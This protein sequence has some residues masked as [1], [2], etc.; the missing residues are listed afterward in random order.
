MHVVGMTVGE[1]FFDGARDTFHR[2]FVNAENYS[3]EAR[4]GERA[5]ASATTGE[6]DGGRSEGREKDIALDLFYPQRILH[7]SHHRVY[8]P[9]PFESSQ[10]HNPDNFSTHKFH[11][12]HTERER[13]VHVWHH[14]LRQRIPPCDA[15]TVTY[16][17]GPAIRQVGA[18]V[19]ARRV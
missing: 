4:E 13:E 17:P 8:H 3:V 1:A 12:T 6:E 15:A 7:A 18:G 11:K 16:S 10:G 9:I 5:R 14:I 2:G 19:Y